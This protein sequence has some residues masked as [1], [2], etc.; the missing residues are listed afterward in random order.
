MLDPDTVWSRVTVA[1]W[2]GGR[3]RE[4]E[5]A[6]DTAVWYCSGL[7]PA[8]IRWA[9]QPKVPRAQRGEWLRRGWCAI[10]PAQASRRHSSAPTSRPSRGASLA[11][12]SRA[13]RRKRRSRRH[14]PTSAWRRSG[15]GPTSPSC[16]RLPRCSGCSPW[17]RSGPTN[18][19]ALR[20]VPS[21]P[22]SPGGTTNASR[23]SATPSPR[24]AA[25]SGLRQV[26]PCPARTRAQSKSPPPC[27]NGSRTHS[28]T[29][30]QTR[31]V[32]LMALPRWLNTVALSG[33]VSNYTG[34]RSD[35][36]TR[37]LRF[38]CKL[39]VGT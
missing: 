15:S 6:S 38:R 3:S 5:V 20:S 17:L 13:G 14:A 19:P 10:R 4:F 34:L 33:R 29:Q 16:A 7:P 22:G 36:D 28:A 23:P 35:P 1:E 8:P 11:D 26:Y 32:D 9:E 31:K 37:F 24:S 27:C 18:S 30:P 12:S 25:R 2:Y 21:A 39:W